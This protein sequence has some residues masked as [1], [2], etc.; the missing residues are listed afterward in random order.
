MAKAPIKCSIVTPE[1]Q[2]LETEAT[3]VIIPAHDGQT[4]ILENR[5]P[6]LC[7]LG[8][9]VLTVQTADD[10]TKQFFVDG[11][12]SQVLKNEVVVLTERAA[13]VDD[14]VRADAE[15]ALADAE[16]MPMPNEAATEQRN[17]A[18]ARAKTQLKLAKH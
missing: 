14:I 13:D 17:R 15:K 3:S 12:F 4:G 11:G 10:G 18:I 1:G 8:T 16:Q 7:E 5:A 2:V 9:G 6:L